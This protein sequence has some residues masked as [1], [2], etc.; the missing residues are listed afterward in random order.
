MADCRWVRPAGGLARE[1]AS[2]AGVAGGGGAGEAALDADPLKLAPVIRIYNE[3]R[4]WI[5]LRTGL[6]DEGMPS[7]PAVVLAGLPMS[8]EVRE[9][10]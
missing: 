4:H 5:D 6:V 10:G 9:T 8:P 1:T 3:G 7:V 2:A